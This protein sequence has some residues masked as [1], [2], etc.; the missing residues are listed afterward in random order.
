MTTLVARLTDIQDRLD[1]LARRHAVPGATLAVALDDELLDFATGVINVNTG[2]TTTPD[3]IFQIGSN[4]KLFTT[5][6]VMQLVDSGDVDLDQ[7]VR[8][9]L[10]DFSLADPASAEITVRQLL[11]HTSGIQG[12]YFKSFGRGDEAIERLVASL[13]DID[14]VHPPGQLWSYCN[15]GF[16]V[17]GRLAE[18]ITGS[19]YHE[20]LRRRI[21]N[22]LGLAQTTVLVEEMVAQRGAVGHVPG[23]DGRPR[24]PPV[25]VMGYAQAPAGSMTTATAAEL[26][27]FVQM[28]LQGGTGP[29]GSQVLSSDS[30]RAMQQVQVRRPPISTAPLTQGLGWLMEEWDGKRL[31]GHGGGT[32][33]QLSFLQAVP[34][35]NLVVA[36]LTNSMTGG[37]L[38]RDLGRW[39]FEDLVGIR[40][41]DTPTASGPAPDLPLDRYAGVYE[42]LGVRHEITVEHGGLLVNT[43]LTGSLA[44]WQQGATPPPFRLRA[45]DQERFAT[46]LD[47]LDTVAV[48]EEFDRGRPQYFF[49]GR[50]ARRTSPRPGR[51]AKRAGARRSAPA[52]TR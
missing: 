32:I 48:F 16:V 51:A 8:R 27:R 12:D 43:E 2:V 24:V 30:V 42:R 47:G 5:T 29:D 11:T 9:Y 22:P 44:E 40:M 15:T 35:D 38:W 13:V 21:C 31:I 25:V 39:L 28:H 18:V 50:A 10:S 49:T 1:A 46:R 4:P 36:L 34:D 6:L 20:L 33:G 23:P 37:L 45:L 19:A 7:P 3:T 52:V 41:P 26:A 14:L 17:A